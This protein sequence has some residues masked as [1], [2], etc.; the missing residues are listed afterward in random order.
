MSDFAEDDF[1]Q[2][3]VRKDPYDPP[4]IQIQ[5]DGAGKRRTIQAT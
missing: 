3:G 2:Y 4:V 5:N 1:S